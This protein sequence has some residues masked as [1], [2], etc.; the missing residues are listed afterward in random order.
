MNCWYW[1]LFGGCL[2]RWWGILIL[3]DRLKHQVSLD[4]PPN[5]NDDLTGYR[6]NSCRSLSP[7][8]ETKRLKKKGWCFLVTDKISLQDVLDFID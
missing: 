6:K 5:R 2:G 8:S 4:E 3:S 7:D 1:H